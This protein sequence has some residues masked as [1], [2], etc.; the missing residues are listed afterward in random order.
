MKTLLRNALIVTMNEND[1]IIEKG[2]IAIDGN[3]IAYVGPAQVA[4]AGPFD[5]TIEA[6]P[7]IAMPGMINPHCPSP[8]NLLRGLMPTKPPEIWRRYYP[9]AWRHLPGEDFY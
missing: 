3:R 1:E 9:A 6:D 5:R 2:A 4:P 8:A 7:L